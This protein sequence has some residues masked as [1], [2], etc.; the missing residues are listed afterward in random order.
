MKEYA[1]KGLLEKGFRVDG[2]GEKAR[3]SFH[4]EQ[5]EQFVRSSQR[6][7]PHTI[8]RPIGVT[9]KPGSK[10]HPACADSGCAMMARDRAAENGLTLLPATQLAQP[11]AQTGDDSG[12][13]AGRGKGSSIGL[14][15][16][17][18]SPVAQP[19]AQ[20]DGIEQAWPATLAKLR[21]FFPLVGPVFLARLVSTACAAFRGVTDG[22]L[23]A[24]VQV[25]WNH[26]RKTQ[27]AEGLFLVTVPDAIAA[28]RRAPKPLPAPDLA[29][30]GGRL[31]GRVAAEEPAGLM[32]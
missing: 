11:V 26:K 20:T 5:W 24:A 13:G 15:A 7:K 25:A 9:P 27:K 10:I 28:L 32:A 2:R 1:V 23:G 12:A 18:A 31:L 6:S 30:G 21:E 16:L 17:S 8:G 4:R 3:F 14:S 29:E 22:E 19:V